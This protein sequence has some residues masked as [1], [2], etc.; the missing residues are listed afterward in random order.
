M[1]SWPT[2]DPQILHFDLFFIIFTM[3]RSANVPQRHTV[4]SGK[5]CLSLFDLGVVTISAGVV[6]IRAV[7]CLNEALGVKVGYVLPR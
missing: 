2:D 6:T 5:P 1:L 4:V 3:V 7:S